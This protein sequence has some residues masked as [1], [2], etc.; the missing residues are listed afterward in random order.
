MSKGTIYPSES[1][2]FKDARTGA[3]I[4]QVTTTFALHHHPFFIIPAY[5]NE[6]KRL[7]FVSHRTGTPQIFA[8]I[9]AT[10][11]LMQLTDRDDLS[12][13]SV[14]PSH[15][16][17]YVFFTAGTRGWR[18]DLDTLE[19]VELVNFAA[20]RMREEGMVGA[21][22]G[23]TALSHDDQWWAIRYNVG[24]ESALSIIDTETGAY[25]IILQRDS[26]G[27]LQFCPDDPSLIYYA[28]PLTD[29]V[30]VIDRDGANNRRLYA[31]NVE[32]NEWITHKI[33]NE[34]I[35]DFMLNKN[36]VTFKTTHWIKTVEFDN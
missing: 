19:E 24:R 17:H 1:L 9:R 33:N 11:E 7:I 31:R 26:I 20:T 14:H 35:F 13:W 10:G 4:R 21:A 22:M 25:E 15:N 28:G 27:H 3:E 36:S 18:L 5:D 30:W 29:R 2:I 34:S 32:K 23:T 8:E 6:M 16:G 12:E